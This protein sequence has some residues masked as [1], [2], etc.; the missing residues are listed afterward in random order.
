M[1]VFFY[2]SFSLIKLDTSF[3]PFYMLC[4]YFA[5]TLRN[6][7]ILPFYSYL[8]FFNVNFIINDDYIF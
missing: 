2:L 6:D 7:V 4:L 5:L 8:I 3:I 1:S